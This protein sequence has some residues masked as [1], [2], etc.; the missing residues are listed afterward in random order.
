M[1]AVL[2]GAWKEENQQASHKPLPF[3]SM[4]LPKISSYGSKKNNKK[5][6]FWIKLDI[7]LEKIGVFMETDIA[8]QTTKTLI[9]LSWGQVRKTPFQH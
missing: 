5:L 9:L 8:Q 4:L 2:A 6:S 7:P 1:G 3:H